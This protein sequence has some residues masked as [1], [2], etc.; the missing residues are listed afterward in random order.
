MELTK[1]QHRELLRHLAVIEGHHTKTVDKVAN[2]I[3]HFAHDDD[4]HED[5]GFDKCP[6]CQTLTAVQRMKELLS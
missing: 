6:Q 3:P 1:Q 2:N 5:E 4:F